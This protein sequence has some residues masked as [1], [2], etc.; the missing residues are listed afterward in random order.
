MTNSLKQIEIVKNLIRETY[1]TSEKAHKILFKDYRNEHDEFLASIFLNKAISTAS[2]CKAIYYSNL[3]DLEN[4]YVE[5]IFIKFD[6]FS[7]EFLNNIST[8]HSHQW[9]DIE[10]NAFT[11]SVGELLNDI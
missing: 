11:D 10:F 2:C 4:T 3:D 7:N 5:N 8:G 1:R 9:T 6:V